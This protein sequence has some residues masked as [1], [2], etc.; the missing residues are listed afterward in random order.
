MRAAASARGLNVVA[1][2]LF[3]LFFGL[4]DKPA[5][6]FVIFDVHKLAWRRVRRTRSAGCQAGV[7]WILAYGQLVHGLLPHCIVVFPLSFANPNR[8]VHGIHGR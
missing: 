8:G 3:R 5:A 2:E 4:S 1:L 7:I 6:C